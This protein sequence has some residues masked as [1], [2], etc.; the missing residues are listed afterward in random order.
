M[1][2]ASLVEVQLQQPQSVGD[3]AT[4]A[5]VAGRRVV[6]TGS[7][8]ICARR[9][10]LASRLSASWRRIRRAGSMA[11]AASRA[12]SNPPRAASR[13]GRRRTSSTGWHRHSDRG[14]TGRAE[15]EAEIG[16]GPA[17]PAPPMRFSG[18][19]SK[20]SFSNPRR[21][22]MVIT[23]RALNTTPLAGGRRCPLCS[24]TER[25]PGPLCR[26]WRIYHTSQVLMD[27]GREPL[28]PLRSGMRT[29]G[30]EANH[31]YS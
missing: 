31:A 18:D 28:A 13:Y 25:C 24:S 21:R 17:A 8:A 9:S 19:W 1:T 22:A 15:A 4:H 26:A 3:G 6:R 16:P 23:H 27:E 7:A 29:I 2:N 14:G 12:S 30:L 5:M 20:F 10:C 11:K